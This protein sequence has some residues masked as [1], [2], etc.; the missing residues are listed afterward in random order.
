MNA[1]PTLPKLRQPALNPYVLAVLVAALALVGG[2]LV[3]RFASIQ[4]NRALMQW[5]NTLNLVADSRAADIDGWLD[6]HFKELGA[7]AGNP[8][9]QLYLTELMSSPDA[10]NAPEE[11][12]QAVFLRNLLLI[13]ADRLGFIDKAPNELKAINANVRQPSGTGLAIV[14]NNGKVL[15]STAGLPVLESDLARKVADAPRGK[16]SLIDIFTAPS[17]EVR[18]GFVI[19]IYPIQGDAT[20]A[21]QI[22]TLVGIKNIDGNFFNLLQHPGITEKTLEAVLLRREGDNVVY[23][24]PTG[25]VQPVATTLALATPGLDA[26]YAVASP[27]NFAVK[28]DRQSHT[29]LMTSRAIANSPWVMMVH[30]DRKQALAES[31]LWRRQT[32]IIMFFALM[33]VIGGIIAVWYYGTS[34]RTLMLSLETARLAASLSAQEKLLRVVADNQLEPILIVD[35]G[36]KIHFANEKAADTYLMPL[37][38]IAGKDLTAL[39]GYPRAMDYGAANKEALVGS[40]VISRQR[41]VKTETGTQVIWSEHIPLANIPIE[42]LPYPSPGVLIVDQDVT[43]VVSERERRVRT[44]QQ[45]INA[46]VYAVDKR[47]PYAANHSIS[48]ALVAR[49]VALGMGLEPK[50]VETAEIAGKLMNVGKIVVPSEL[51]TKVSALDENEVKFIR[52][53]LQRSADLIQGI[54]FDGPVTETLLQAQENFD[55]TGPLGLKG[56]KILVTARVIMVANAFIGMVSPRSYHAA[57]GTEQAIKILLENIDTRFDRRVVVSL[58]N[59]IENRHGQGALAHLTVSR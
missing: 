33:A 53:S 20:A 26:A 22:G 40:K 6:R 14:D 39:M 18:M 28:T 50:L 49:E 12:P 55:G 29:T 7:V 31:D 2:T 5:Q 11:P 16:A 38:D 54:E 4:E 3:L 48:V 19:P 36:D 43:E 56:D 47:D 32:E 42:G 9:L 10:K 23:L 44:L 45:V 30:I 1:P 34:K 35:S 15:V 27:G 17:G 46:L 8:S 59:F 24:S 51:L 57:M 41:D 58:A 52:E 21:Q 25:D 13:T 37:A